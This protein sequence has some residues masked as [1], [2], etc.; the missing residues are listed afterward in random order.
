MG[1][2]GVVMKH[3]FWIRVRLDSKTVID[4]FFLDYPKMNHFVSKHNIKDKD[5]IFIKTRKEQ[6]SLI[7]KKDLNF[8]LHLKNKF[9]KLI[10][11]I[12]E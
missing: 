10:N 2:Q 6:I 4:R 1:G 8:R 5:I 3:K 12:G 9:Q 7:Q 11:E